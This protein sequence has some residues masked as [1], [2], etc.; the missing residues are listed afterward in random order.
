MALHSLARSSQGVDS[1]AFEELGMKRVLVS[2][3]AAA[4]A[5]VSVQGRAIVNPIK[6]A[7]N[8]FSGTGSSLEYKDCF[9]RN[10]E[11]LDA[12]ISKLAGIGFG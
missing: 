11:A 5:L 1:L 10:Y 3:S 8:D 9:C 2:L 7:Q 12:D 4:I 6:I